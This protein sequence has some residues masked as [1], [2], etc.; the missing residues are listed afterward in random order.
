M[1]ENIRFA[2]ECG[3]DFLWG[4]GE[5]AVKQ[6]GLGTGGRIATGAAGIGND[7]GFT[8]GAGQE[9]L[10]HGFAVPAPFRQGGREDEGCGLPQPVCALASQ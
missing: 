6:E 9:S 4:A 1:K 5:S 7:R 3:A 2:R 8:W 10:S